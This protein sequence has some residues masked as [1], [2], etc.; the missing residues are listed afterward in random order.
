[1]NDKFLGA[2]VLHVNVEL[3]VCVQSVSSQP[4]AGEDHPHR[5][6]ADQHHLQ[7]DAQPLCS[8]EDRRHPDT[9]TAVATTASLLVTP[10]R[11]H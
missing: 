3:R 1:M 7:R 8:G 6:R 10:V 11:L 5:E 4:P 2:A 9:N